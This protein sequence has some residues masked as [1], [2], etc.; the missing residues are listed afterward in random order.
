[1]VQYIT[2]SKTPMYGRVH[3]C[4]HNTHVWYSTL[5][6]A[7]H[8][9]MVWYIT[10][11]NTHVW[12]GTLLSA[13]HP[14]MVRYITVSTTPTYGTVHYCSH[15]THVWYGTLLSAQLPC[16]ILNITFVMWIAYF[17]PNE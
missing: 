2:V 12:Y 13:Q 3:Y 17:I 10:Q 9:C 11:H 5:L 4:Q 14:C 6:S 16:S 15:N 8:P 1:M 7:Q